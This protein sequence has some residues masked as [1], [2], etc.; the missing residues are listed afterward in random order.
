MVNM[1]YSMHYFVILE[2]NLLEFT[3]Y[4]PVIIF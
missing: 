1:F 4:N 2:N 3:M